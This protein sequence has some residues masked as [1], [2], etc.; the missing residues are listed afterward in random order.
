M[1]MM[2]D[3]IKIYVLNYFTMNS[4]RCIYKLFT[5]V[6]SLFV[7]VSITGQPAFASVSGQDLLYGQ[8]LSQH[9]LTLGNC[10]N[11]TAQKAGLMDSAGNVIYERN[12][13]ESGKIASMTKI[14]TAIICC[15]TCNMTDKLTISESAAKVGESSAGLNVGDTLT[16]DTALRSLLIPSGNDAAYAIAEYVGNNLIKNKDDRI[17]K[18]YTKKEDDKEEPIYIDNNIEAF[19]KLMNLKA[20]EL[21]C[22]NTV[23]T[24]PH[25][26]DDNTW[27]SDAHSCAYDML[28]IIKCAMQK[29]TIRDIVSGGSCN[30]EVERN[31]TTKTLKLQSTDLLVG[32]YK[33]CIGV[34]TGVTDLAGACFAGA[35]VD[36]SGNEIYTVVMHSDDETQRFLDTQN[37]FEWYFNHI[38]NYKPQENTDEKMFSSI[39]D[40][41]QEVGIVAKVSLSDWCNSTIP[42]TTKDIDSHIPVLTFAGNIF[43]KIDD[44]NVGGNYNCGDYVCDLIILQHNNEVGRLPLYAAKDQK[45]PN[46][47]ELV[48]VS[49]NRLINSITN[50]QQRAESQIFCYSKNIA[51]K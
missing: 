40:D 35:C 32:S 20:E 48:G 10:P 14:M 13:L 43:T 12:S 4:K 15:E 29:N 49:I 46:I 16:F 24:N 25:G 37:L 17:I 8:T 27:E 26:L 21:G 7:V 6:L 44:T 45:S 1:R 28:L 23:F 51:S 22:K 42:V 36:D 41:E 50:S 47:F 38:Y 34:K 18:A 3:N 2:L 31:N 33:G 30:I 39:Y 9:K 11:I 19:S 5:L